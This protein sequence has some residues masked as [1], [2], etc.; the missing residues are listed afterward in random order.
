MPVP[1]SNQGNKPVVTAMQARFCFRVATGTSM[2]TLSVRWQYE[3]STPVRGSAQR[4]LRS[5][6]S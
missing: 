2:L 1:T 4:I 5:F 3:R 6:L